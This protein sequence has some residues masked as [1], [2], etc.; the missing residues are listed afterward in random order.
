MHL[1]AEAMKA[2]LEVLSAIGD[3]IRI[4]KAAYFEQAIDINV[5]VIRSISPIVT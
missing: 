4:A 5:R 1:C 3:T 2:Q